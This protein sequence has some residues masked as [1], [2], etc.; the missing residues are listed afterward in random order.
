MRQPSKEGLK[1]SY[2]AD[3]AL[4]EKKWEMA[5]VIVGFGPACGASVSP[6]LRIR[7]AARPG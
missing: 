6:H 7:H 1:S 5:A 4:D 2:P 3:T